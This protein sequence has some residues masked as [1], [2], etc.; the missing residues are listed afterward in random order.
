[1]A[2]RFFFDV[3]S[4]EETILDLEGVEAADLDEA[5]AEA[6]GVI[7]E[8]AGAVIETDPDRSWTMIVRDEAGSVV[9]RLPI[10]R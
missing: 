9:G 7:A 5:L 2:P 6:R 4:D 8:M 3:S 1:M 10:K